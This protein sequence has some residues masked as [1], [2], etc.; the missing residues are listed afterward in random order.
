[1][2]RVTVSFA[3][4]L[5]LTTSSLF[6]PVSSGIPAD[7]CDYNDVAIS[8]TIDP[9]LLSTDGDCSVVAVVRDLPLEEI[10]EDLDGLFLTLRLSPVVFGCRFATGVLAA[11]AADRLI[12]CVSLSYI[13]ADS[14]L[15]G[16]ES[17][18]EGATISRQQ[19]PSF[20][21][22]Y[23]AVCNLSLYSSAS[24][25]AS[26][27]EALPSMA[28]VSSIIGSSDAWA[29]GING[30]GI[31]IA[32]I[33]TGVDFAS[34]GLGYW[35]DSM[36]RDSNGLPSSLD[37]DA[38]CLALTNI[39]LQSYSGGGGKVFIRTEGLDPTIYTLG[40][41]YSYSEI[42]GTPFPSDMEVTGIVAA[43]E[44]CHFGVMAQIGFNSF[45][46][47]IDLFPVLVVDNDGDS[48][49]ETVYVDLSS[50][51]YYQHPDYRFSDEAALTATGNVIAARD[52][53]Y[54]KIYDISA[55]SLGRFLDIWGMS[56]NT[57][58]RGGVLLPI[59]PN[60]NYA[61][62]MV[63]L[64]GHGTLCANTA[65]ARNVT[66]A[67]GVS[68]PYWSPGVAP[69]A[70][71]MGI[72]SITMGNVI[73]GALWAAGFDLLPFNLT[74][75]D[76]EAYGTAYGVWAYTGEHKA[77]II[78][79]S[80][81]FSESMKD[82]YGYPWYSI[83]CCLHDCL[84]IPHYIDPSY[85]GTLFLQSSGNGAPGY[86]T[87]T[88]P[89]YS[90]LTLAVGATTSL[91]FSVETFG[92]AGG[93]ADE[94]I[95][96]SGRGPTPAGYVKPDV[97][98][99][100]IGGYVPAAV[101]YGSKSGIKAYELFT[102]TS[103]SCPLTA[104]ASA[105]VAQAYL[106]ANGEAPDPQTV[107]SI[108][109]SSSVDL[110]YD[111]FLQGS[112]RVDCLGAVELALGA[113]GILLE[114]DASYANVIQYLSQTWA[115]T[116]A[117]FGMTPSALP[118][119]ALSDSS[120]FAGYVAPGSNSSATL[121]LTNPTAAQCEVELEPQCYVLLE[122]GSFSLNGSTGDLS[123]EWRNNPAYGFGV[124]D[125]IVIPSSGIS[126][127]GSADL[128]TVQLS[129]PFTYF[130]DDGDYWID[131]RFLIFILDWI[132]YD[133]DGGCTP[134]ETWVINYG[135]NDANS[136][137]ATVSIPSSKFQGQ[138]VILVS[139]AT[140]PSSV[141]YQLQIRFWSRSDWG[142]IIL[143]SS[144]V[145]VASGSAVAVKA[146]MAVPSSASQGVYEGLILASYSGKGAEACTVAFPVSVA[147]P[148]VVD[149]DSL[150]V[151]L[152]PE[153]REPSLY[154]PYSVEGYFD[155]SWRFECGDWK[156]WLVEL[157]QDP[158]IIAAFV[159]CDWSGEWTDIDLFSINSSWMIWDATENPGDSN[160][161]YSGR[162]RLGTRDG[163]TYDWVSLS[164]EAGVHT[165][166]LHNILFNGDSASEPVNGTLALVKLSGLQQAVTHQSGSY[167]S[168]PVTLSSGFEITGLTA[169][170]SEVGALPAGVTYSI[171]PSGIDAINATS[172]A[173]FTLRIVIP[174]SADEGAY[175]LKLDLDSD[176]FE[177]LPEAPS[178]TIDLVIDDTPPE[179]SLASPVNGSIIADPLIPILIN[180]SDAL[181]GIDP[182]SAVLS[183]D[184]A[185][186]TNASL[187]TSTSLQYLPASPFADG[188]H[189]ISLSLSDNAGN[190]ATSSCSFTIDTTPPQVNS[191]SVMPQNNS[192][193]SGQQ[194]LIACSYTDDNL[195]DLSSLSLIV[196]GTEYIANATATLAGISLNLSLPPGPH[197]VNLTVSDIAGNAARASWSF[198]VSQDLTCVAIAL[199]AV[200][201]VAV[202]FAVFVLRRRRQPST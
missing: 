181:S 130:D 174:S 135:Y 134:D 32:I 39:T 164:A 22:L 5:F 194:V 91:N 137:P 13:G 138:P 128:M 140:G 31:T 84:S 33:D 202:A 67:T 162:F 34:P 116:D 183:I 145:E 100:G 201:L 6:A 18:S 61:S 120:W 105:L 173:S 154:D 166:L 170:L 29:L 35:N 131:R 21:E 4:L 111:A 64:K 16:N 44:Q 80:W 58:D 10:F 38:Q 23:A 1:M 45:E 155:W 20:E 186:A 106:F 184:G 19:K 133:S 36:S 117:S 185:D 163:G 93:Y 47:S 197:I 108:L 139:Q 71:I 171:T 143:N 88:D 73:E 114:T 121:T 28:E 76:M 192:A 54:D 136:I 90:F 48:V 178:V 198:S 75:Y 78:S 94:I 107:R 190:T 68:N 24:Y 53:T 101:N 102:G 153:S 63:D 144:Q 148:Q 149:G 195:V 89:A 17:F 62:F 60:G 200:A 189:T 129:Y 141:P 146:T 122:G 86:G 127:P 96:W 104:G 77:D 72:S 57:S 56:P 8:P 168:L 15:Y 180:F 109:K 82:L 25:D 123:D 151:Q 66:Q 30:S 65:A 177:I 37:A 2:R 169:K 156:T 152:T 95:P 3:L 27:G 115:F 87:V 191:T 103:M 74:F 160:Y 147:V 142:W 157:P 52:F 85:S 40:Y 119:G 167:I 126:I 11:G 55:G 182:S 7:D 172:E 112:G 193:V 176:Q 79:C 159:I 179:I 150:T 118:Q 97:V 50:V 69:G 41:T 125:L 81:G 187:S 158:E 92:F 9:I 14:S 43:G 70:T 124:G 113:S 49:F 46:S 132:D 12:G 175:S 110:G 26:S 165:I 59:D 98:N 196:D 188:L 42:T 99:V 161:W 83:V 51:Y 199:V